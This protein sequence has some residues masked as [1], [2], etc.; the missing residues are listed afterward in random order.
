[1]KIEKEEFITIKDEVVKYAKPY[2]SHEDIEK[3]SSHIEEKLENFQPS[4][5]V[6]GTYNAGKSTL[7]NALFGKEE[8]AKT[9]DS[10]ET[11]TISDYTYNGYT[12]YDTPGI[13]APQEHEAITTEHLQKCE[14]ILF[15]LSNGG[16]FEERFI[17][18]K[19]SEIVALNK[20]LLIV[21]NNKM[22]I[23]K[24]SQ[25]EKEQIDKININLSKIGDE[26]GIDKIESKVT[27]CV[28]DAKLA[29]KAKVENKKI[30]LKKSNIQQLETEINRL[31]QNS[32]EK[33]VVNALNEYI[34]QFIY[35]SLD[36]ID[37][38]LDNPEIQK[39][40]E[41]ITYLEKLKQKNLIELKNIV[42]ETASLSMNKMLEL[43]TNPQNKIDISVV[44]DDVIEELQTKINQ[45]IKTIQEEIQ[46]R[47]DTLNSDLNEI[48]I[49]KDSLNIELQHNDTSMELNSDN[50]VSK[51]VHAGAAVA[52]NFVPPVVPVAGLP[53]PARA[54]AQVALAIFSVFS[55]SSGAKEQ[56][57]AQLDAKRAQYLSSKN[58]VDDFGYDLKNKFFDSIDSS[59][60]ELFDT[61]LKNL[62]DL[63]KQLSS[64]NQTLLNDK[65]QLQKLLR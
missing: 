34:N 24:N 53:I 1:M 43:L 18:E 8:M 10:P 23:E 37:K 64:D 33:E 21:L 60:V 63:S 15:V 7:L 9:G 42:S 38:Q 59:I 28:V 56:A 4:M 51:A 11:S 30:L 2:Q 32:G 17:Y 27:L 25:E 45:Q 6:Y 40:E 61:T 35:S 29:L 13:N 20:P 49:Q 52:V 39:T 48:N 46:L 58:K 54:I 50:Q 12:I 5:M 57:Q 31:L 22:G 3:F 19:I 41:L 36:E 55:G 14:L 44:I 62:Y 16:S 47:I 65:K 26:K